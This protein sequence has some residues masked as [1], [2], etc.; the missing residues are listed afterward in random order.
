MKAVGTNEGAAVEASARQYLSREIAPLLADMI[1][2]H[3]SRMKVAPPKDALIAPIP[4]HKS[5]ERERGFN[6]SL[7]IANALG[8]A[9]GIEVRRDLVTKIKK[10]APQMQLHREERLKNLLGTFIVPNPA[11]VLKRTIVLVDDVKTTGATIEEAARVLRHAG[12]KR[13]WAITA[14]H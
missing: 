11:S 6:Q 1:A 4:L 9:L 7:L 13:V 5:R 8:G 14:A 12:A 3:L 2:S 10:T